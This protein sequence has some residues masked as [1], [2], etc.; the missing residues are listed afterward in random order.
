MEAHADAYR[1]AGHDR[2][3]VG[4]AKRQLVMIAIEVELDGGTSQRLLGRHSAP[5]ELRLGQ[6]RMRGLH[7]R[8]GPIEFRS[9]G[10][11]REG[12]GIKADAATRLP[13]AA[14]ALAFP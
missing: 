1:E 13:C 2:G 4:Q 10:D 12:I 14:R 8:L 7:H 3:R 6:G 9:G 11:A 5:N